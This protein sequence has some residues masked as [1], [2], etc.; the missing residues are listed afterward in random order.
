MIS[1][2]AFVKQFTI[3]HAL[4]NNHRQTMPQEG[5]LIFL[6]SFTKVSLGATRN[7]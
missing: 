6:T 7:S 4:V 2:G 3:K 1:K 5:L